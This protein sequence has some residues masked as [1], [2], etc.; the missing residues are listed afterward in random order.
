[1]TDPGA[2]MK[3]V[4]EAELASSYNVYCVCLCVC[5]SAHTR[6]HAR[7]DYINFDDQAKGSSFALP[8]QA[9]LLLISGIFPK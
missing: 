8:T 4:L 1:M 5:V 9:E 6:V 7:S 3:S 2:P